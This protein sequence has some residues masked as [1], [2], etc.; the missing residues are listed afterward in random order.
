MVIA[1]YFA[2]EIVWNKRMF[3]EMVVQK[4]WRAYFMKAVI[5]Q[6]GEM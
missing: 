4:C 5:I 3:F 1:S 2:F 6:N